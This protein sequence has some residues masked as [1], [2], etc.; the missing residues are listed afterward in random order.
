MV[1]G[2]LDTLLF[3]EALP[4]LG[5]G[6][7]FSLPRRPQDSVVR[8]VFLRKHREETLPGQ[9]LSDADHPPWAECW[10]GS[11]RGLLRGQ[12]EESP[13]RP[14]GGGRGRPGHPGG[15]PGGD[16]RQRARVSC[17]SWWSTISATR[18]RRASSSWTPRSSTPTSLG[19][20]RPPRPP[21]GL[22]VMP[23]PTWHTALSWRCPPLPASR[24]PGPHC[25]PAPEEGFP[26]ATLTW[27]RSLSPVPA[28]RRSGPDPPEPGHP[29][30]PR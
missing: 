1:C 6:D 13:T 22:Q 12:G 28:P 9:N 11:R 14:R 30:G 24:R 10:G 27:A 8:W 26:W 17:R 5:L 25:P 23:T 7:R 3:L 15:L 19:N 16:G 21:A 4:G 18:S 20:A 2:P 29:G